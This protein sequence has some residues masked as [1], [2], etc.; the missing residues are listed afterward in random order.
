MATFTKLFSLPSDLYVHGSP[1]VIAAGALQQENESKRVFVQLKL[2]NM[3]SKAVKGAVVALQYRDAFGEAVTDTAEYS[4]LD[5]AAAEGAFFGEKKLI[6]L[7]NSGIRSF[8]V[9]V[10]KVIFDDDSIWEG[11]PAAK[12]E[13]LPA[14]QPLTAVLDS[15]LIPYYEREIGTKA[16]CA[17]T[18]IGDLWLCHCGTYNKKTKESCRCGAQRV[19]VF[20]A[21]N[22]ELLQERKA[23]EEKAREE[24][25]RERAEQKA[26]QVA[27]LKKVLP[28]YLGVIALIIAAIIVLGKVKHNKAYNEALALLDTGETRKAVEVLRELGDYKDAEELCVSVMQSLNRKTVAADEWYVVGLKND[29][30]VI[31]KGYN[32]YG[33]TKYA[34]RE[35]GDWRD[36]SEIDAGGVHTIGLKADGTVVA[37]GYNAEGECNVTDWADIV[38]ISAGVMHTVGLKKDGTVVA[39]GTNETSQ[40]AV[41]DWRD[42]VVVS[43]GGFH[44]IGLKK[45]GRVVAGGINYIGECDVKDWEGIVAVSAGLGHTVGLK[46]D[47]TVLATGYSENG[48]CDVLGWSD[49]NAISAGYTHTVGLKADGTVVAAGTNDYGECNVSG[50]TDIAAISAGENYTIGLKTDG[51]VV[52]TGLNNYGQCD[53]SGWRDIQ[54]P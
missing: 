7:K 40:C 52:A 1:V 22:E 3:V 35:V 2:R 39:V 11:D 21:L 43:A 26:A 42:I 46:T 18:D 51:T 28:F 37:T 19:A 23:A 25:A 9:A 41:S 31:D 33:Y 12:W 30:T 44:T 50:W 36:I 6:G 20:S 34:M 54:L 47:G 38:A 14:L 53:V 4:Y 17:P 29:G 13:P 27:K 16:V 15:E 45:D 24:E 32:G 5:L 49:I 10:K 48:S 8:E